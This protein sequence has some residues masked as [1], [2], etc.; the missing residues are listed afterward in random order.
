MQSTAH[1]ARRGRMSLSNSQKVLSVPDPQSAGEVSRYNIG[2][3]HTP[4]KIA[5]WSVNG[6][7]SKE[8]EIYGVMR[9]MNDIELS[10]E[11][12]TRRRLPSAR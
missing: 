6:A 1:G 11:N 8:E 9:G 7:A 12:D 4:M 2:N 5:L 3:G 10:M